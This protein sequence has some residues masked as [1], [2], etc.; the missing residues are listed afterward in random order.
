MSDEISAYIEVLGQRDKARM[1][2]RGFAD[3]FAKVAEGL[4][5]GE[6]RLANSDLSTPID[7][8]DHRMVDFHRWPDKHKVK[9]RLQEYYNLSS[10]AKQMFTA[11]PESARAH[12]TNPE[13]TSVERG[14]VRAVIF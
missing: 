4:Q 5:S 9:E 6:L 3:Y 2:L 8:P 14:G 7:V 11:L 1:D 10:Q 13:S 12:V